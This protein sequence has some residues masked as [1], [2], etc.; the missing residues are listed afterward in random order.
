MLI[1][2]RVANHR[3]I[4]DEQA[5]TMQATD[6]DPTDPRPR[7]VKG[8]A[9]RLVPAAALYGANAS[10]KSNVLSALGFM[11]DA[12]AQSHRTWSPEGGIPRDPFAWGI[13]SS[14]P[15]LF[16]ATILVGGVRYQYG[17]TANDERFVEEWLYAWPAS[18]KQTWF[19]RDSDQFKFGEHL[20]GP[21]DLIEK[22]T[23]PNA[24][25][26]S[27]AVQHQHQ[28]LDPLYGWFRDLQTVNITRR[29]R[30][31]APDFATYFMR[32]TL[33]AWHTR[34]LQLSLFEED[35]PID[36]RLGKIMGLLRGADVGILDLK[37][38]ERD[39][40]FILKNRHRDKSLRVL[41]RHRSDTENAWLP[42]EEESQGTR[43]LFRMGLLLLDCLDNGGMLLVDELEGSLHPA[44]ALQIL[45]HF[46]NPSTNPHNAQILFTTHDT[47]L[48]GTILGDAPLRRDQVW[49]TE[50]DSEGATCLYPLTDYKP[51][52]SENLERGYL[53]GR[54]GA[55]PFL[56]DL[57]KSRN[58]ADGE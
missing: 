51:R 18:R 1:E 30:N 5:L 55:I 56:G 10:G 19:F 11:R 16:E 29:G 37:V 45:R 23:R 34:N 20:K 41:L 44:L 27:A 14:E 58:P 33:D 28:Q 52:P 6:D 24:L 47:H 15:S 26:L 3:S 8:Y 43:T 54:Y 25:F 42:L 12:V 36:Q 13:Q 9:R 46:N 7:P 38:E 35:A 40:S 21:N 17:F 31:T 2:F 50:K 32:R 57:V 39:D 22:V 4:R 53:Q 49:L 48:L